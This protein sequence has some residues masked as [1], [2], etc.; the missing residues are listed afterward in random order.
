MDASRHSVLGRSP[1]R[2][3]SDS[4]DPV[5]TAYFTGCFIFSRSGTSIRCAGLAYGSYIIERSVMA[6]PADISGVLWKLSRGCK[7]CA[8]RC[9]S[10]IREPLFIYTILWT[11]FLAAVVTVA[12]VSPELAF[13]SSLSSFTEFSLACD[14]LQGKYLRLPLDKPGDVI[15]L[16]AHI[17]GKS[18][19]DFLIPPIFA[20]VVVAASACFVHAVGLWEI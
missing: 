1:V 12:S 2:I 5:S 7:A 8:G 3:K 11:T 19:V 15:C 16:P 4:V 20:A 14:G 18:N 6:L 9:K 17:F 13:T 10:F